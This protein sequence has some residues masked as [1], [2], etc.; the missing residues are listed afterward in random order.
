M[1]FQTAGCTGVCGRATDG[2]VYHVVEGRGRSR[3]GDMDIAWQPHDIFVAPSWSP[4]SHQADDEAVLFSF[5]DRPIQ[6]SL[7][8]FREEHVG[9]AG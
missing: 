8:I 1:Y 9:S 5:S 6:K 7:G 4:V 3:I 2:T